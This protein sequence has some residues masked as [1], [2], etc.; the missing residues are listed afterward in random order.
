M[1]SFSDDYLRGFVE[2]EGCFYVSF[3]PSRETKSGWQVIHFFKVSQNPKGYE[4]LEAIKKRLQCG[5]IKYNA[6][7]LSNDKSLAYVVRNIRDLQNKVI[8]FFMNKLTIKRDDFTKF[9]KV[10]ELVNKKQHL[11][12]EGVLKI[13]LITNTMNTG[14][15]KYTVKQIMRGYP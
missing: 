14:K 8:P 11:N 13:I 9:A 2:G 3:V 4:V 10:I 1:V 6:S 7:S 5:Y 15:R 12:K